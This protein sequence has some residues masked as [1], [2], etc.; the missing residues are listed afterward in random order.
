MR[1]CIEFSPKERGWIYK[2]LEPDGPSHL[3]RRLNTME[4]ICAGQYREDKNLFTQKR[5][6]E[7]ERRKGGRSLRTIVDEYTMQ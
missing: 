4:F 6:Q 1:Q 2:I 7:H 3:P 5:N